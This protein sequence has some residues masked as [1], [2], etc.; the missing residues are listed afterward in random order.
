MYSKI[1]SINYYFIVEFLRVCTNYNFV[2]FQYLLNKKIETKYIIILFQNLRAPPLVA[3][4][5]ETVRCLP[6]RRARRP[7]SS[8]ASGGESAAPR[9]SPTIDRSEQTFYMKSKFIW[10][11]WIK[12]FDLLWFDRNILKN[13]IESLDR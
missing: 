12:I 7:R 3:S 8:P 11:P 1:P 10:K 2:D 9:A 4:R 6:R 5:R 13:S